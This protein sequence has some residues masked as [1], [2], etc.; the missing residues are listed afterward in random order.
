MII[1]FLELNRPHATLS[2]APGKYCFEVY[3]YR[4]MFQKN[5][6]VYEEC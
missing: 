4:Q 6:L 3:D 1:L 5:W 2:Y